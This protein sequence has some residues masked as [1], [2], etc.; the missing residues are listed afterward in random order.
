MPFLAGSYRSR[1]LIDDRCPPHVELVLID[2]DDA[3]F[4]LYT[5]LP[6]TIGHT[7]SLNWSMLGRQ[8][9]R[10]D[11]AWGASA[12]RAS[13]GRQDNDEGGGPDAVPQAAMVLNFP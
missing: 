9:R 10:G 11:L 6:Y 1:D 5:V 8:S 4:C 7:A 13:W 2:K 12:A 3:A